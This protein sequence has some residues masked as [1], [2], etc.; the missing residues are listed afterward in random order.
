MSKEKKPSILAN[1]MVKTV[2]VLVLHVIVLVLINL[3]IEPRVVRHPQAEEHVHEEAMHRVLEENS[4]DNADILSV[5]VSQNSEYSDRRTEP[6][7]SDD[8]TRESN[9]ETQQ[10][11]VVDPLLKK[12]RD[13]KIALE[14]TVQ[15]LSDVHNLVAKFFQNI[16]YRE[17]LKKID[18]SNLPRSVLVVIEDMEHYADKFLSVD[19]KSDVIFPKQG[20]MNR[21]VGRFIKVQRSRESIKEKRE[22]YKKI[23]DEMHILE[24]YFY[25]SSHSNGAVNHD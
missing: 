3:K 24:D 13:S 18:K 1:E 22:N 19:E 2:L 10:E 25:P 23:C 11:D 12:D 20:I 9:I 7:I 6:D 5:V 15:R 16:D 8:S 4:I 21:A 17:D 14:T